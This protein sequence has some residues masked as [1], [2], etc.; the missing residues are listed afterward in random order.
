MVAIN[1]SVQ[2]DNTAAGYA[3]AANFHRLLLPVLIGVIGIFL[4]ACSSGPV[5]TESSESRGGVRTAQTSSKTKAARGGGYYKDDGPADDIPDNLDEI[6]DAIPQLEPLH[7]F[8]NRPYN[9]L[10]QSYVPKTE[11]APFRQQGQASWYGRRFH[12][13]PTSSGEPYDMFG[14]TAAHP[15]LPIPSY[16][17]VTNL[18][19]QRSVVVRVN[20]RGPF[21]KERV[22]DLS[23]TA[24]YKLGYINSGSARV[25]VEQ[26]IP[27]MNGTQLASVVPEPASPA[28]VEEA[29]RPSVIN[30]GKAVFVQIGAFSSRDNAESFKN[31]IQGGLSSVAQRIEIFPDRGYFRLHAGP[32]L[33]PQEARAAAER[34]ADMLQIEPFIVMR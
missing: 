7:R 8:A 24:A 13:Q 22:I 20:D 31:A 4:S 18:D 12:N 2:V 14:M 6:P 15:T 19:N 30:N 32:Y 1:N 9:V 28:S 3:G 26:I 10:G 29:E 34:I 21:H 25:A 23:Y 5:R 11:L 16:V 33:S 27:S 17:R